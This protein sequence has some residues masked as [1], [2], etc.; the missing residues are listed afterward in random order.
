M[1]RARAIMLTSLVGL[2]CLAPAFATAADASMEQPRIAVA[3]EG[4]VE[5]VPD[6]AVIE[7]NASHT[8]DT[9][10]AAKQRADEVAAAVVRAAKAHGIHSDDIQASQL[11]AAPEYDW[12]DG[13]RLLRGQRVTRQFQLTLRNMAQYGGLVQA[14]TEAEVTEIGNI[15]LEF[16]NQEE[17]ANQALARAI[18]QA[19]SK[20]QAMAQ[21][22]EVRLEG[23]ISASEAS[24]GRGPMPF[25]MRAN[26]AKA[27][28]NSEGGLRVGQQ[29][30]TRT[31][32]AVF[33]VAPR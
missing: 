32:E 30:L 28:D 1:T 13:E 7:L 10:A 9:L 26:A 2:A 15:R 24:P 3:G 25:E 14:L 33:G 20:A 18:G 27:S 22:F 4:W 19:R 16:S 11:I 29:R 23:L 5:A 17:L 12:R 8:A 21:A 6:I 31:V